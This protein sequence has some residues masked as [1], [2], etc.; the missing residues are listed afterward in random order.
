MMMHNNSEVVPE[1]KGTEGWRKIKL[2]ADVI[3]IEILHEHP[4][5]YTDTNSNSRHEMKDMEIVDSEWCCDGC[6][7]FKDGCK[8][9]QTDL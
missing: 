2:T 1:Q 4:I 8:S 5:Q 3:I 7:I 6:E 9:G